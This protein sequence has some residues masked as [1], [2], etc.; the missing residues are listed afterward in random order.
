MKG[1]KGFGWLVCIAVDDMASVWSDQWK[2]AASE[3]TELDDEQRCRRA[4]T[5]LQVDSE[6]QSSLV[7]VCAHWRLAQHCNAAAAVGVKQRV[8]AVTSHKHRRQ[9]V[10]Q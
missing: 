2:G 6:E 7:S 1:S 5:R 10:E 4:S 9:G 8:S 3:A